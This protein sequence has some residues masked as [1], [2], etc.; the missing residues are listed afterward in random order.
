[1]SWFYFLSTTIYA[2]HFAL[3]FIKLQGSLCERDINE[4]EIP[5]WCANGGQCVNY[6]GAYL[7]ICTDTG[8]IFLYEFYN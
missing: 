7:C 4:C 5:G 3:F 6:P 1:M 2:M 8:Q